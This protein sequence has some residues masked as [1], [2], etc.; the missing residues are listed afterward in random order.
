[1]SNHNTCKFCGKELSKE[2]NSKLYC[3]HE[4]GV[5]YRD[6]KRTMKEKMAT[7]RECRNCKVEFIPNYK[8]AKTFDC[9]EKCFKEQR[10]KQNRERYRKE[11]GLSDKY[12]YEGV[13]KCKMCNEDISNMKINA[14]YCSAS[15]KQRAVDRRKGHK[16][17]EEYLKMV[18]KQ[19]KQRLARLEIKAKERQKKR[20]I[21]NIAKL[22]NKEVLRREKVIEL[23]RPCVECGTPFYNIQPHALTCSPLCSKRR[24]NRLQKLYNS[25]RL[26]DSNIVDKDITLQKLFDKYEGICYLC[27]KECDFND[28][29]ITEEG[30]TIVGKTYPS[31]EH[32]IPI[33][34]NGLHS[35]DN[36]NL[37]HHYCNSIKSDKLFFKK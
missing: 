8:G 23:T 37:A 3:S 36:V 13:K 31:I 16:S 10:K 5:R 17:K 14:M 33:S 20:A 28:K 4:C 7:K 18:G 12:D 26:N 19:R 29:V 21:S 24:A 11:N 35:W 22:L 6:R 32:V 15:C 25:N 9:S 2:Y 1:M 34:K 30:Y 27:G